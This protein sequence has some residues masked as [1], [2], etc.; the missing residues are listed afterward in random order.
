MEDKASPSDP[1]RYPEWQ[2]EYS[3]AL[4][5]TDPRK[6][7]ER[8][9]AAE[10]CNLQTPADYVKQSRQSGGA[11]GY[12]RCTCRSSDSQAGKSGLS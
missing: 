2:H 7:L 4:V 5:E 9:T 12:R 8:V 3:A 10:N 11:T 6:L 1:I